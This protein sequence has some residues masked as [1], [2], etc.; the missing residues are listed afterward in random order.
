M[1]LLQLEPFVYPEDLLVEESFQAEVEGQWWVLHTRPRAEKSLARRLRKRLVAHFLPLY[2]R[3]WRSGSRLRSSY[4]PLFPGYL[5]LRG[6]HQA[7]LYA[8]ETNL[9]V[10]TL[11]VKDQERLGVDLRRVYQL[12]KSGSPLAPEDRLVPGS[13]VEIISGPLAGM[14]G[15]ILRR[16]K[17]LHFFVEIRM[18]QQGVSV[19]MESWMFQAIHNN[20]A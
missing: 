13:S 17:K 9:V 8:L 15:K 12:V 6:D 1:P 18:L 3:E 10:R 11:E 5:F 20:K 7:R 4:L 2:H 16:G 14:E 19:E